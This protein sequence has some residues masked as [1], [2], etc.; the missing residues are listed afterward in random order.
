MSPLYLSIFSVA[1]A[2]VG[3]FPARKIL[4]CE[5]WRLKIGVD[6][7][8]SQVKGICENRLRCHGYHA[9]IPKSQAAWCLGLSPQP[10]GGAGPD[11]LGYRSTGHSRVDVAPI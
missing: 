8:A 6:R 3:E 10:H 2:T 9:T 1:S 11:A 4:G 5:V 7:R